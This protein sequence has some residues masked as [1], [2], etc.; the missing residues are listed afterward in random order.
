[1]SCSGLH[2][3]ERIFS[4]LRNSL[5]LW[6][7]PGKSIQITEWL[8]IYQPLSLQCH[9]RSLQVFM[10]KVRYSSLSEHFVMLEAVGFLNKIK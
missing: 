8:T 5:I 3:I 6:K 9:R 2:T 10:V 1:M 4:E 7:V